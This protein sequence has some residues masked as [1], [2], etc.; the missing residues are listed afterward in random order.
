MQLRR[1]MKVLRALLLSACVAGT[2]IPAAHAANGNEAIALAQ[3]VIGALK[4]HGY[5]IVSVNTTWLNRVLIRAT[6]EYVLREIV[7]SPATGDIL[8]DAIVRHPQPLPKSK[9]DSRTF[10]PLPSI[11]PSKSG[12]GRTK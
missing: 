2:Y 3:P 10:I 7:V 11:T 8:R 5:T 1:G 12:D 4:K 6:N 9:P